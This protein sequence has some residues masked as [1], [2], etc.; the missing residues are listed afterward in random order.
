MSLCANGTSRLFS[1]V[2]SS[3]AEPTKVTAYRWRVLPVYLKKSSI[4]PKKFLPIW[5]V[6]AALTQNQSGAEENRPSRCRNRKSRSWICC[7]SL[8]ILILCTMC[9]NLVNEY[10]ICVWTSAS[11][12]RAAGHQTGAG[13]E[14]FKERSC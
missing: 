10:G 7:D 2:R 3:Q 13:R 1:F 6:P 12:L 8:D 11:T 5:K 14:D 9:T 4:A